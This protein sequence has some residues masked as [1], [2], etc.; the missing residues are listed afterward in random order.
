MSRRCLL[1]LV[2]AAAFG[3]ML[4][5]TASADWSNV[6]WSWS[7][8]APGCKP[9]DGKRSDPIGMVF[10][11]MSATYGRVHDDITYHGDE[12]RH[13]DWSHDDEPSPLWD[14]KQWVYDKGTDGCL[15]NQAA[16]ANHGASWDGVHERFHTRLWQ[17]SNLDRKL[18][19][20]TVATPH[21]EIPCSGDSF[22]YHHGVVSFDKGRREFTRLVNDEFHDVS[23]RSYG[24]TAT[25]TECGDK[26]WKVRSNGTINWVSF[27]D[28]VN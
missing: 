26:D 18:R 28:Q 10:Y 22:E 15:E 7:D 2:V 14:T 16:N 4:V 19:H 3:A 21:W 13:E 1:V 8:G 5:S 17:M 20:E 9:G 25:V 27:P 11:G 24:E 6:F 12:V 23:S